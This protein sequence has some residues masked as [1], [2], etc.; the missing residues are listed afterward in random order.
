MRVTMSVWLRTALDSWSAGRLESRLQ[1]SGHPL[2]SFPTLG[3]QGLPR[4][5]GQGK[6]FPLLQPS[7]GLI[8][9]NGSVEMYIVV[10]CGGGIISCTHLTDWNGI[11]QEYSQILLEGEGEKESKLLSNSWVGM[12]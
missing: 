10:I 8:S 6:Q 7:G 9:H 3:I 11:R 2:L 5:W 12:S 1:V 4:G